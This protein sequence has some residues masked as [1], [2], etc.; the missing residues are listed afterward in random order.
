MYVQSGII[1]TGN[2]KRWASGIRVR[3]EKLPFGYDVHYSSD[4]FTKTPDF[5]TRQFMNVRNLH[6][7][8]LDLFFKSKR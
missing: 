6:L 5:T 3:V 4:G 2:Y 8:L 1:A 7:C